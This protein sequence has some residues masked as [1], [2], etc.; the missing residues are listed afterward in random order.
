MIKREYAELPATRINLLKSTVS[1]LKGTVLG[2]IFLVIAFLVLA[3]VYTYT[4]FPAG[5]IAPAT[6]IITALSI[7]ICAILTARNIQ[8]FGW[9][10]GAMAGVFY[11]L[12]RFVAISFSSGGFTFGKNIFAMLLI[13]FLL[14]ALGGIIGINF[15]KA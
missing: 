3:A 10:H 1:V 6:K 15:K 14:G 4:P 8:G 9:L 7:I 2:Y 12:I 13:G 11:T 5:F